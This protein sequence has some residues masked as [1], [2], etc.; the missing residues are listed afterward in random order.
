MTFA[1]EDTSEFAPPKRDTTKSEERIFFKDKQSITDIKQFESAVSQMLHALTDIL[2]CS[3][4]RLELAAA[5]TES[6]SRNNMPA[7]GSA[8]TAACKQSKGDLLTTLVFFAESPNPYTAVWA[9]RALTE[10]A[11]VPIVRQQLNN[12]EYNWV[13]R[14]TQM[15]EYKTTGVQSMF[16]IMGRQLSDNYAHPVAA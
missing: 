10:M 9:C 12:T 8:D 5:C 15:A 11:R 7:S 1:G 16:S 3:Q 6:Q 14:Q 4:T 2:T 13:S